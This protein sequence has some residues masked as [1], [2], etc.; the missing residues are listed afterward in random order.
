MAKQT[1]VEFLIEQLKGYEY[2]GNDFVFNGVISSELIEQAK[3]M[4][5]EQIM[6]AYENA[7]FPCSH[8]GAEHYYNET[9]SK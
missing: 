4:E 3:K 1:A 7:Y 5:K 8:Y 9:F 6:K 2:D